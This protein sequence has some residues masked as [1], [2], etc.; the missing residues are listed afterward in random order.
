MTCGIVRCT[1]FH[2]AIKV[3][4]VIIDVST[5]G[6]VRCGLFSANQ[7]S[8][9][10]V[11]LASINPA[12]RLILANE[13][14]VHGTYVIHCRVQVH[15]LK[16]S[17]LV[18]GGSTPARGP[19]H[20]RHHM[21]VY[22]HTQT[23]HTDEEHVLSME[24]KNDLEFVYRVFNYTESEDKERRITTT[25]PNMGQQMYH[26]TSKSWR[27]STDCLF[28]TKFI[29]QSV[30][31]PDWKMVDELRSKSVHTFE[32]FV[33]SPLLNFPKALFLKNNVCCCSQFIIACRKWTMN[34]S[35]FAGCL[36]QWL[37]VAELLP[38]HV[39]GLE[40]RVAWNRYPNRG[41]QMLAFEM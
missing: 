13:I 8:S 28:V 2:G 37:R 21:H 7:R 15:C 36:S 24:K 26:C 18:H 6:T 22:T 16:G 5:H 11:I 34:S 39:V 17:E 1:R 20:N 25:Y 12:R 35:T 3:T 14:P 10:M 38:P 4:L 27:S 41:K 31:Q 40:K 29:V 33:H 19:C 32:T 30:L 23:R 9:S